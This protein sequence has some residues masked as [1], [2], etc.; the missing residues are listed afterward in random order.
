[1]SKR[2]G[3][4]VEGKNV[5]SAFFFHPTQLCQQR[6]CVDILSAKQGVLHNKPY[7]CH[8]MCEFMFLQRNENGGQQSH[9]LI[10]QPHTYAT[11]GHW[12]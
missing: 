10:L 12:L 6:A 4:W 2:N 11:R 7:A 5:P 8:P 3:P 9:L 1:M